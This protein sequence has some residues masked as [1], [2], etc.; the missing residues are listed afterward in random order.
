MNEQLEEVVEFISELE[1]DS[2]VPRN[3]KAKL[4]DIMK[5]LKGSN[6]NELSLTINKLLSDLD[7]ISNDANLDSFTRQQIWSIT[8][9]L[10][11]IETA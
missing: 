2:N 3:I 8:S 11:G 10:E 6:E 1:E 9:M 7:D 5:Q 4:G